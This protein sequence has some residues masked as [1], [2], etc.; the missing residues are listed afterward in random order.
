MKPSEECFDF[1][2]ASHLVLMEQEVQITEN[3]TLACVNKKIEFAL[4]ERGEGG[5]KR[6]LNIGMI[7]GKE[8]ERSYYYRIFSSTPKRPLEYEFHSQ[9]QLATRR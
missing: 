2:K 8:K 5:Y 4:A 1:E 6:R 9:S 7:G 3:N